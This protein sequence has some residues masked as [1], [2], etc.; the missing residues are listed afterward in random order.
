[1]DGNQ[2]FR[3]ELSNAVY[4]TKDNKHKLSNKLS[5]SHIKSVDFSGT[6]LAEV[7]QKSTVHNNVI[8]EEL[9]YSFSS[10]NT[11]YRGSIAPNIDYHR[12]TSNRE[13]F[14]T[15]NAYVYGVKVSGQIELPWSIRMN[16]ELRSVSRRGYAYDEM[17]DDEVIWNMGVTKS[18]KNNITLSLNVVDL[19][20]QHKNVYR[21]VNAQGRMESVSNVL[22]SY[23]ML[24]FVWQFSKKHHP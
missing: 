8:S 2:N 5:Y 7:A 1:M 21:V 6:S 16:T 9:T 20:N 24:H 4:L 10:R 23:A 22:R 19:L 17:N 11:K 15:I 18:F 12:S 13:G 3:V 14:E